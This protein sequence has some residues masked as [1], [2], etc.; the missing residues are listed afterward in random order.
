MQKL[1]SL[2]I[3]FEPMNKRIIQGLTI[4]MGVSIIGIIIIQL[5]WMNNAIKVRSELFDRSINEALITSSNR[6]ETMQNYRMI[7]HF[8]FSDSISPDAFNQNFVSPSGKNKPISKAIFINKPSQ[9]KTGAN[10]EMII[11]NSKRTEFAYKFESKTDSTKRHFDED[12][13]IVNTDSIEQ[14][15]KLRYTKRINKLDSL[16]DHV[17]EWTDTVSGIQRRIEIKTN[18]LKK[19]ANKVVQE[20][21]SFEQD[22]IP[23]E[24]ISEILK[25]EFNNRNIT[26]PFEFGLITDSVIS[27]KSD[28][29][30]DNLLQ[31]TKY[32]VNLFPNDIIQK[33]IRLSVYFPEKEAFIYKSLNWLLFVSLVFS[34]I[35]LITFA[36]SIYFLLKQKKVSQMKS[37]FINNMT[38][39]FKTPLATIAVAADSITNQKIIGKPEQIQYFVDMI[40]KENSRMNKQVEDILTIARMDKEEIEFKL[41]KINL[42]QII[43]DA[44]QSIQLQVE[45]KGGTLTSSLNAKN[46]IATSDA[47]HF[48]NLIYNLLDNA[49]KYSYEKPEIII[50]TTNNQKGVVIIVEDKG[51][52]MNKSVQ[53]KIFEPFYRLTSGNIHNVKGFGLGLSYVKAVIIKNKGSISVFSEPGKGSRFEV[54]IPFVLE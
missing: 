12:I 18:K 26:I 28:Y 6:L 4:L 13:V 36:Y 21:I 35:V 24:K 47:F 11:D 46:P 9:T 39:E 38:H 7:N 17:A 44:L 5:M 31:K 54:F 2:I 14:N 34:L 1:A 32:N 52:G 40:K 48:A 33:N 8:S 22:D 51:I 53:N 20:I 23:I 30:L 16:L 27:K 29:A 49:N 43:K 45:K 37:D 15:I 3:I 19:V 10:F 41:E 42:H 50:S 25:S